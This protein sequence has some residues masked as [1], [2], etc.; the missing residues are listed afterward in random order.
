[1]LVPGLHTLTEY[2][3]FARTAGL[4]VRH[5]RDISAHVARTWDLALGLITKPAF[6]SLAA[7]QGSEFVSFLKAFRAMRAGYA[8]RTFEYGMLVAEKPL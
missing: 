8:S 5:A 4:R 3:A 7:A 1:M 2:I 6:W